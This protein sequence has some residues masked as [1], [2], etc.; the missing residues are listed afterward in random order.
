VAAIVAD[1]A[2]VGALDLTR[3]RIA[4][5]AARAKA[6]LAPMGASGAKTELERLADALAAD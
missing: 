4:D 1:I 6:A 5:Y 3:G 2:R